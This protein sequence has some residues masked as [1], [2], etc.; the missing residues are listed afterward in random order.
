MSGAQRYS[1]AISAEVGEIERR[2]RALEK[3][4]ERAGGTASANL[5]A[6]AET[7]GDI[8]ASTLLG[9]AGRFRRSANALGDQSSEFGKDAAKFGRDRLSDVSAQTEQHPF[10]A[11]GVALAVGLLIGLASRKWD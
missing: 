3:H 8:V 5:K 1:R 11:L 2:L 9:W 10:F 4:L 7:F 6:S